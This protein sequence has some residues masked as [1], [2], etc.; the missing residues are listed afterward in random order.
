MDD[1]VFNQCVDEL[2]RLSRQELII[3]LF[4]TL[5]SSEKQYLLELMF[6][7]YYLK[8]LYN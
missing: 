7:K 2:K 3:T 1:V 6:Y 8:K 4:D 5:S